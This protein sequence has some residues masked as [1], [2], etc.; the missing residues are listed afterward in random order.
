DGARMSRRD[1]SFPQI[2]TGDL[3]IAVVTQLSATYLPLS[4]EFEPGPVEVI[5]FEAPFRRAG[6]RKQDLEDA[7]GNPHDALIFA[8]ADAELDS[9][10]V[11]VPPGVGRKSEKH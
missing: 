3:D 2:A 11:G 4:D 6:F 5:G 7:P 10:A 8:D 1:F 9:V